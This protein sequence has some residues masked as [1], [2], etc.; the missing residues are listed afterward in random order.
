[1][2]GLVLSFI[3]HCQQCLG[4]VWCMIFHGPVIRSLAEVILNVLIRSGVK[5]H[6]YQNWVPIT[7]GVME[8]CL[9][10]GDPRPAALV[11]PVATRVPSVHVGA[12]VEKY[13]H[14]FAKSFR[15]TGV[16]VVFVASKATTTAA[17]V[18]EHAIVYRVASGQPKLQ[19]I[20]FANVSH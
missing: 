9:A 17:C 11:A 6:S 16:S 13:C 20:R 10:I 8:R 4:F 5:Q 18:V 19:W 12:G 3:S 7:G 14:G 2:L 1:M 15:Q